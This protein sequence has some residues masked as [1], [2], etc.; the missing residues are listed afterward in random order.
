[1]TSKQA[2]KAKRADT[3]LRELVH[4]IVTVMREAD[5]ERC[6]LQAEQQAAEKARYMADVVRECAK[7]AGYPRSFGTRLYRRGLSVPE[8]AQVFASVCRLPL[9]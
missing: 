4:T 1:M 2:R 5:E 3:K 8:V 7:L 9:Q 6:R